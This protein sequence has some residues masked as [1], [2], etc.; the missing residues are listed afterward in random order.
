MEY[1]DRHKRLLRLLTEHGA[2]SVTQL[3]RWLEVSSST[4]RRDMRL[5]DTSGQIK[6]VHGG[7]KR[8]EPRRAA[9]PR[10]TAGSGAQ[11]HPECK[12]AIARC[13][14]ALCRDG[15][16]ILIGGGTTTSLMADFLAERRMR[17]LTNSFPVARTLLATSDN[18]VILSGGKIYADQN[19]ILSPFDS[20]AIQHCYADKLFMGVHGLTTL[21]AMEA[22]PLLI[23]AGRRLIS[24]ARHVIVLADSSKFGNRSGMFLCGLEQVSSVITDSGVSDAAVQMLERAGI[25]VRVVTPDADG[26]RSP[27][28]AAARH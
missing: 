17:V 16:T 14:A 22:D 4:V 7:G 13:A 25:A 23:Q 24:Q 9:V 12:R 8:I 5:L 1:Q 11:Q 20:E 27:P 19:I 18:E 26:M 2:A 6:R 28:T 21:G 10:S 3:A 15:D